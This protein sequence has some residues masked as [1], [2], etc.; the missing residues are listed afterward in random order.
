MHLDQE[1]ARCKRENSTVAVMVC[2]LNGFKK[3]NDHYGHLEGDKVLKLFAKLLQQVCRE[4][5]YVARM[6]GDEFVVI[7]P[8]M[9]PTAVSEKSALLS[10]LAQ[11]AGRQI[12][13]KDLLSLSVGAAF[14]PQ[15]GSDA[16]K[17]LTEADRKMYAAKQLHYKPSD[18]PLATQSQKPYS[19]AVN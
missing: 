18:E 5:D 15:D 7:A 11:K 9:T 4:Y 10:T 12:C 19:T 14:F 8:N 2:D 17:L 3:V 6:G 13:G 16:E 1:L